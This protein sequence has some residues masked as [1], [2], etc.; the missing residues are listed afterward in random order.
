MRGV[1]SVIVKQPMTT[2]GRMRSVTMQF[3]PRI[4]LTSFLPGQC[5]SFHHSDIPTLTQ[6]KYFSAVS[7][8]ADVIANNE[9]LV[10]IDSESS[11]FEKIAHVTSLASSPLKL[12]F[13]QPHD[14]WDPR[15]AY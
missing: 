13:T 3:E 4:A 11:S 9:V 2:S 10:M 7:P 1:F 8:A 12:E 5:V 6:Y 15:D 14:V